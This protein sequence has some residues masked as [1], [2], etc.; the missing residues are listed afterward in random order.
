MGTRFISGV[1]APDGAGVSLMPAGLFN[2]AGGANENGTI[3][4]EAPTVCPLPDFDVT[5]T[6]IMNGSSSADTTTDATT[7]GQLTTASS[8]AAP[9][10]G[11][12]QCAVS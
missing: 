4:L 12:T 3:V 8:M 2:T 10:I 1:I 6:D 5:F 7:A 9:E 11:E